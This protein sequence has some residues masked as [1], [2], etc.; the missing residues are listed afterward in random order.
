MG[1]SNAATRARNYN[2]TINHNQGGGNKK[3]GFPY[4]IGRETNTS[5]AFNNTDVVTGKCCQLK[6]Y[7]TMPFTTASISR[8]IGSR[9]NSYFKI[10]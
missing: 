6:S 10:A 2:S 8:P 7:Q 1:L 9:Y 5:I 3:A 4:L